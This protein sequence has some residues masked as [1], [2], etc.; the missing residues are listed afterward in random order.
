ML[1]EA[2]DSCLGDTRKGGAGNSDIAREVAN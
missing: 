2:P 1:S